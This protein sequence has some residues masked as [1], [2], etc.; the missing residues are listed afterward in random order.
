MAPSHISTAALLSL[1]IVALLPPCAPFSAPAPVRRLPCARTSALSLY[2]EGGDAVG[3]GPADPSDNIPYDELSARLGSLRSN[4]SARSRRVARNWRGGNWSERALRFPGLKTVS[5]ARVPPLRAEDGE[6]STVACVGTDRDAAFVL[7]GG[8]FLGAFERLEGGGV[9]RVETDWSFYSGDED[10]EDEEEEEAPKKVRWGSAPPPPKK[11]ATGRDLAA[12]AAGT[13][14]IFLGQI[15][16]PG[17]GAPPLV[18]WDDI[19]S[20]TSRPHGTAY[21]GSASAGIVRVDVTPPPRKT[22]GAG[23]ASVS[24]GARFVVGDVGA[25]APTV[26][27]LRTAPDGDGELLLAVAT[28]G[29]VLAWDAAAGRDAAPGAEIAPAAHVRLPRGAA[30]AT[31]WSAPGVP[32]YLLIG[33]EGGVVEAYDLPSLLDPERSAAPPEPL[34]SWEAHEDGR[35]EYTAGPQGV[36]ALH[37]PG[38]GTVTGGGPSAVLITGGHDGV[39]KQWELMQSGGDDDSDARVVRHWPLI[40]SQR[41]RRR[42]HLMHRPPG[43]LARPVSRL[44]GDASRVVSTYPSGRSSGTGPDDDDGYV[45]FHDPVSGEETFTMEGLSGGAAS[46]HVDGNLM[47]CDG[48][49]RDAAFVHDF[50]S[51]EEAIEGYDAAADYLDKL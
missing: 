46:L 24:A 1:A 29:T 14:H 48:A 10:D 28:D 32:G 17:G 31:T 11:K 44:F 4:L 40:P 26:A 45:C 13:K 9:G 39:V 25:A 49:G 33:T 35:P 22:G 23:S 42:A 51:V 41:T 19:G 43:R 21:A 34:H 7:M 2:S 5:C 37:C 20:S 30:C 47:M 8:E 6:G 36:T 38:E 16:V 18:I 3:G 12:E 27:L 15:P 50:E